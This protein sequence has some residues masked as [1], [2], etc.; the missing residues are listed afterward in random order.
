MIMLTL[1]TPMPHGHDLRARDFLSGKETREERVE[2]GKGIVQDAP[3]QSH[4]WRVPEVSHQ[5]H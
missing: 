2:G 4:Y 3:G 5:K 1:Q